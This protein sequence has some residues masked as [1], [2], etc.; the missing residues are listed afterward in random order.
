MA[1]IFVREA[2]VRSDQLKLGA[3]INPSRQAARDGTEPS[4]EIMHALRLLTPIRGHRKAVVDRDA[5]DHKHVVLGLYL[6]DGLHLE[7]FGL[8][9]D[10]TRLQRAGESARQSAAGGGYDVVECGRVWRELVRRNP[11]V[12]SDLGMH[13]EHHWVLLGGK[14]CQ[15]LR[16]AKPLDAHAGHVADLAH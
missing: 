4:V 12:L 7:P 14:V 10:L 3:H 15:A 2:G 5:L 9:L 1:R 8:D 13:S 6:A 11:V 16:T